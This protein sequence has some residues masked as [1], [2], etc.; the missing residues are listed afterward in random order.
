[1]HATSLGA[2]LRIGW[3]QKEDKPADKL[4]RYDAF[5]GSDIPLYHE[6][7]TE[8]GVWT[9]NII[10]TNHAK[11]EVIRFL[12]FE[13]ENVA[14]PLEVRIVG[15]HKDMVIRSTVPRQGVH[16]VDLR[17]KFILPHSEA[18]F[19]I[20]SDTEHAIGGM[21]HCLPAP[22]I[23]MVNEY[24]FPPTEV[25]TYA[26]VR[27]YLRSV[28]TAF[29]SSL[30][31]LV[32]LQTETTKIPL[33]LSRAGTEGKLGETHPLVVD[34]TCNESIVTDFT[35]IPGDRLTLTSAYLDMFTAPHGTAEMVLAEFSG[36]PGRCHVG[37]LRLRGNLQ[38][39]TVSR[40]SRDTTPETHLLKQKVFQQAQMTVPEEIYT[41]S[42]DE[43]DLIAIVNARLAK[44]GIDHRISRIRTSPVG[45]LGEHFIY[46]VFVPT[47]IHL[48]DALPFKAFGYNNELR[49]H[50][51]DG[52]E[53][54]LRWS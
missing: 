1:M 6:S 7:F 17:G 12:A 31:P 33:D 49:V 24:W 4:P 30:S 18:T 38:Y 15:Q 19:H 32:S 43:K 40:R 42:E 54:F 22:L 52:R 10:S 14:F 8:R 16:F 3:Q 23:R 37:H 48:V 34:I 35:W 47:L 45:K 46:L 5:G 44:T 28:D 50:P 36:G 21:L 27:T 26:I 9:S 2:F 20:P 51:G 53:C 29:A 25:R 39:L 13:C 11:N 41:P